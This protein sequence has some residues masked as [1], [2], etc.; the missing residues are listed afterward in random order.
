MKALDPEWRG[1]QSGKSEERRRIVEYVRASARKLEIVMP[2]PDLIIRDAMLAIANE[3][4]Q[5]LHRETTPSTSD[6]EKK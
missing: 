1:R 3:I 5:G 2:V 6:A 4:E